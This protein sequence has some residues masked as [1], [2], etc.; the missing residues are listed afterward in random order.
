MAL[1][2]VC[3]NGAVAQVIISNLRC[4][5]KS[6]VVKLLVLVLSSRTR[7]VLVLLSLISFKQY[8]RDVDK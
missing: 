2:V 4:E 6:E 1:Y 7:I 8:Y 3:V 5:E